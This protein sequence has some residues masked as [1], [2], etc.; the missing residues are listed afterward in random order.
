MQ[1]CNRACLSL[2]QRVSPLRVRASDSTHYVDPAQG[3]AS[4]R[5]PEP[6][7]SSRELARTSAAYP[8]RH[9]NRRPCLQTRGRSEF[10]RKRNEPRDSRSRVPLLSTPYDNSD[11]VACLSGGANAACRERLNLRCRA[12]CR[13]SHFAFVLMMFQDKCFRSNS[14]AAR[15]ANDLFRRLATCFANPYCMLP[16]EDRF[17]VTHHGCPPVKLDVQHGQFPL[18]NLWNRRQ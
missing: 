6:Y 14:D 4:A 12:G 16:G 8:R 9:C 7:G 13:H 15:F 17:P 3:P 10:R 5:N 11:F 18:A 2:V 1:V